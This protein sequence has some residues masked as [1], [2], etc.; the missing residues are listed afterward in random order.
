MNDFPNVGE[1]KSKKCDIF[2]ANF[3]RF[4][5]SFDD[6]PVFTFDQEIEA[7]RKMFKVREDVIGALL[8]FK[9]EDSEKFFVAIIKST[10]KNSKPSGLKNFRQRWEKINKNSQNTWQFLGVHMAE[11][12]RWPSFENIKERMNE[13]IVDSKEK[14]YFFELLKKVRLESLREECRLC[15]D[16]ASRREIQHYGLHPEVIL[17]IR[18]Q[19]KSKKF[20]KYWQANIFD[21]LQAMGN[22][23]GELSF[24]MSNLIVIENKF[25][26]ANLRLVVSTAK[27]Q[28]HK[29]YSRKLDFLDIIQEGNEGLGYATRRFNP[30]AGFKF[31]TF[32]THWI[33]QRIQRAFDNQSDIIRKPVYVIEKYN[34]VLRVEA[35]VRHELNR[36][37]TVEEISK[38]FKRK[39]PSKLKS[40]NTKLTPEEVQN[41]LSIRN[42]VDSLDRKLHLQTDDFTDNTLGDFIEDTSS[43]NPEQAMITKNL[44][45]IFDEMLESSFSQQEIFVINLRFGRKGNNAHTLKEIA[46]VANVSREWI[47][48]V[49]NKAIKRF[50]HPTRRSLLRQFI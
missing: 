32:A 6:L 33:T 35:R 30:K 37:P 26:E 19:S 11:F 18:S 13:L 46:E 40:E 20:W 48:R 2:G 16:L 39:D 27:K 15:L 34:A 28:K 31:S 23:P 47:R 49:E 43:P 38:E 9:I 44:E 41:I 8:S 25:V 36:N 24:Q 14:E 12:G 45:E 3:A 42:D 50:N 5:K 4:I 22:L 1:Q 10:F 21:E 17:K 7:G 29:C